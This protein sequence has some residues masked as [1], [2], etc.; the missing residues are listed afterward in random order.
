[1]GLPERRLRLHGD[2]HVESGVGRLEYLEVW[3]GERFAQ[4]LA[5]EP[6]SD[7]DGLSLAE[8]GI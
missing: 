2:R 1:M 5:R 6:W 7:Q 8:Y 3:N 4:K